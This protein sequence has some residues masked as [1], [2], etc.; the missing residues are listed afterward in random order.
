MIAAQFKTA[1]EDLTLSLEVPTRNGYSFVGWAVDRGRREVIYRSGGSYTIDADI[2]LYAVWKV[3]GDVNGDG[4]V[5]TKDFI[6]LMRYCAEDR[7]MPFDPNALDIDGSG[8]VEALDYITLMQYL[9]GM[10]VEIH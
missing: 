4:Y 9:A 7:T 1:G 3:P 8:T 6:T 10:N 2:T 5:G